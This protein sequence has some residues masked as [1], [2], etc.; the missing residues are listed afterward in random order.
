[1]A[2]TQ[3]VISVLSKDRP[4]LVQDITA[5]IGETGCNLEDSR[6]AVLG[7]GFAIILLATGNWSA[8]AKLETALNKLAGEQDLTLSMRR[9]ELTP[10]SAPMLPY[11]VDVVSLDHPGI[12]NQLATFLSQRGINILN[13][14]THAY[15]AA[16]TAT[17]MFAV[18]MD[19]EVPAQLHVAALREDFLDLCDDLNL[20][21][22][23]EPAKA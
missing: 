22:V 11:M 13:L 6:A 3:L 5:I 12:V 21:G 23:I 2:K 9:T 10:V 8:V 15:S 4:G 14:T 1:M 18:H 16:H 7:G 19:I 17:P 20:D